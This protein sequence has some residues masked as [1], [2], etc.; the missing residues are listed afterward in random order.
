LLSLDRSK[1]LGNDQDCIAMRKFYEGAVG[2]HA[3][4][5]TIVEF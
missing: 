5:E 2:T 1:S 3:L 4:G